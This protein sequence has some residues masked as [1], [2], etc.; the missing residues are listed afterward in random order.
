MLATLVEPVYS[1]DLGGGTDR[2]T[3]TAPRWHNRG[4]ERGTG[5]YLLSPYT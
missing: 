3:N 1:I 4:R 5:G 2:L